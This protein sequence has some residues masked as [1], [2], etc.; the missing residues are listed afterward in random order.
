ML[1]RS[2]AHLRTSSCGI[3]FFFVFAFFCP[4]PNGA[5][6]SEKTIPASE[7]VVGDLICIRPDESYQI[8]CD[9]VLVEGSCSVDE[10]A[11]TG[12]SYPITKVSLVLNPVAT[13]KTQLKPIKTQPYLTQPNLTLTLPNLT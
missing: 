6:Q 7:L 8:Q 9:A 2:Q 10:S 1:R 13:S 4:K 11:L 12:E 3:D 5:V